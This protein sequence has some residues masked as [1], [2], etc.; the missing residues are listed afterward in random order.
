MALSPRSSKRGIGAA[1]NLAKRMSA[2]MTAN[3][4]A[5]ANDMT[6]SGNV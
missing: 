2:V 5:K 6:V 1:G 4:S 3:T